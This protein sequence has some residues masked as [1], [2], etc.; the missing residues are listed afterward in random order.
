MSSPSFLK[1]GDK[2]AIVATARKI[3]SG[4]ISF[5]INIFESWGL[6]VTLG[7]N[8]FKANHQFAG[9]DE[10]RMEDFQQTMDDESIKAIFCARGGYGTVRII[11]KIYFNKFK[12][13][14]KWVVGYSDITVLHSH[15]F[16]NFNIS[17]N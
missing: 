12:R 10:G 8:I 17:F 7:K 4:E 1:K 13:K 6:K 15:L 16:S 9:T 2:V 3:S 11:D 14:P 5:A